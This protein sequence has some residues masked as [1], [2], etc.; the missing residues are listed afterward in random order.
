MMMAR[1]KRRRPCDD[2]VSYEY[3][4]DRR[5]VGITDANGNYTH[6]TYDSLS[7]LK[8]MYFPSKTTTGSHNPS[9]YEE[10]TY[11]NNNNLT[12]LRKRDSK[13]IVYS[14]D[15]LNRMWTKYFPTCG[16]TV[17]YGYDLRG[18]VSAT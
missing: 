13:T 12:V 8:R 11:D 3:D 9:D 17:Y 16:V 1:E 18:L 10:Y 14:Y 2:R 5:V 4:V 6:Q 7:R 15:A